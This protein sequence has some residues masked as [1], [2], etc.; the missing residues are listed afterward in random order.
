MGAARE[1]ELARFF[2]GARPAARLPADLGARLWPSSRARRA[3]GPICPST[4][5]GWSRPSRGRPGTTSRRGSRDLYV[6]DLALALACADGLPNAL[7]PLRSALRRRHRRRRG[8]RRS[9]PRSARRGPPDPLAADLR[10]HGRGA[11]AD[12]VVRRARPAGR[13]GGGGG[14]AGGAGS[15]PV[16]GA[17]G[18]R[19]IRW[20]TSSCRPAST[21]RSTTC[22]P[23]TRPSSR[24]PCA[25]RSAGLPD[26][27]RLLLKLTIVSGLSHEQLANIYSVNQSTITRWIAPGARDGAG[28]DRARGLRARCACRPGSSVRW[29][30]CSS[31]RLDLSISRVLDTPSGE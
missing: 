23:A 5:R 6:E 15:A 12:P 18:G 10:R 9:Q 4:A 13:L 28:G 3:P 11:T 21:R 16:G 31:R 2:A 20:P 19:A 24:R 27:D 1:A 29:P 7:G 14:A 25:R 17:G 22:A 26:R 8:A 30:A